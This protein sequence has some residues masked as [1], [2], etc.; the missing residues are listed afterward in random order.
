MRGMPVTQ[1]F[2]R[3]L[4]GTA[5]GNQ[6]QPFRLPQFIQPVMRRLVLHLPKVPLELTRGFLAQVRELLY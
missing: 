3:L 1:L 4:D 5:G 6:L 2:G